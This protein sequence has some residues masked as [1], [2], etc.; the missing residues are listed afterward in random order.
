MILVDK[1]WEAEHAYEKPDV[2]T[3]RK[4]LIETS[5]G[6]FWVG[7]Y[8]EL[9][10]KHV[11]NFIRMAKEG[12]LN[13]VSFYSVRPSNVVEFGGVNSRDDDPLNDG[14]QDDEMS[15]EAEAGRYRLQHARGALSSVANEESESLDRF[16]VALQFYGAR[17]LDKR[18]TVFGQVL[19]EGRGM[20]ALDEI[21]NTTTYSGTSDDAIKEDPTFAGIPDHPI[22][23]VR[24]LRVSI[25]K[26]DQIEEGHDWETS[27]VKKPEIG[28]NFDENFKDGKP[29]PQKE[30][31]K[32]DTVGNGEEKVDD[33]EDGGK[34]DDGKEDDGGEDK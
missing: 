10:P 32:D 20:E 31:E 7:F 24:V 9:A 29:L 11:E 19:M 1:K 17:E 6:G 18:Q 25:W 22:E 21:A 12:G 8:P 14:E 33:K 27:E 4:A 23:M 5:K 13:G 2:D 34:E 3:S 30:P 26:A 16:A 15:I 28:G